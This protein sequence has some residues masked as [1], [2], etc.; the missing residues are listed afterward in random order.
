MNTPRS[1]NHQFAQGENHLAR[2]QRLGSVLENLRSVEVLVD[3][4]F[5]HATPS[6]SVAPDKATGRREFDDSHALR[7]LLGESRI[8]AVMGHDEYDVN[9]EH[10]L[11]REI[12]CIPRENEAQ[13]SQVYVNAPVET[14]EEKGAAEATKRE[15]K[16]HLDSVQN[17]F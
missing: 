13:K 9:V 11:S 1:Q 14:K 5:A 12:V 8:Q 6:S 10:L 17:D 15:E 4:R 3:L 16:T 2:V 7:K